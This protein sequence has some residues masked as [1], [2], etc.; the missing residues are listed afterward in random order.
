MCFLP[1]RRSSWTLTFWLRSFWFMC[2]G[3][4]LSIP[5]ME[6]FPLLDK[7]LHFTYIHWKT[8]THITNTM[9]SLLGFLTY[10]FFSDRILRLFYDS[11][12]PGDSVLP[13]KPGR[14]HSPP[15]TRGGNCHLGGHSGERRWELA[16]LYGS[17]LKPL[18]SVQRNVMRKP[19]EKG[20]IN[21]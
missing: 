12:N 4:C 7:K 10:F 13:R 2:F 1:L 14:G 19:T 21:S 17:S 16:S 9:G 15:L 8:K 6:H 11:R 3:R 18:V 20:K 5:S